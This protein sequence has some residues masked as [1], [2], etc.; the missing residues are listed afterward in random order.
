M[1]S[2]P[3]SF[4]PSLKFIDCPDALGKHRMA[5]W[6]WG[7]EKAAHVI[8]CVHGLTRQGRDFDVLASALCTANPDVRVVCPD[9]VGRG[10]SEWLKDP[11][12][13][14]LPTYAADMLL[15][16][17]HLK[18]KKLD[19]VGTSMGGLI[20]MVI[21]GQANLPLTTPVRK[22]VLNDVGPVIEWASLVRIGQYLGKYGR[23][24][25][26]EAAAEALWQIGKGFGPHTKE[27]WLAL[28][29]PSLKP[30]IDPATGQARGVTLRYDPA[31]SQAFSLATE[32]STKQG[33]AI[34]WALYDNI[35]AQTLLV[36]GA[37]SDLLS[38]VT[39]VAM[40]QRG[41]KATLIE[42]TGVGHAPTFVA[43]QQSQV[44]VNFL[45]K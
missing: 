34:L 17:N 4:K 25:S 23:Y 26:E 1:L 2:M 27:Q 7:Q 21:A 30:W 42:F 39:A 29:K 5:Y 16:L 13:Y 45:L 15:L 36:R 8:C 40:T 33:E 22:L 44:V 6:D 18:P 43:P 12:A 41:P 9:V 20:G 19:W 32:A 31:I 14:A 38:S 35:K 10:Q 24:D 37:E 11:S 28:T 3:H